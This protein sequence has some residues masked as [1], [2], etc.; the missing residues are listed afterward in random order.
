MN[1]CTVHRLCET[2]PISPQEGA[3]A[4]QKSG[5]SFYILFESAKWVQ[6]INGSALG[7]QE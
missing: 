2:T 1:P 4:D 7:R 3:K 5:I 6:I